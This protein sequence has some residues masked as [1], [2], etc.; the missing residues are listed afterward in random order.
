MKRITKVFRAAGIEIQKT[1]LDQSTDAKLT[2]RTRLKS[3]QLKDIENKEQKTIDKT[4]KV[5]ECLFVDATS[6]WQRHMDYFNFDQKDLAT[7]GHASLRQRL[8]AN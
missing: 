8:S 2:T 1:Y 7:G 3:L 6:V 5:L 4:I